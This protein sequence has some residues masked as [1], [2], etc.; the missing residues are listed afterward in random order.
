MKHF[1]I[2]TLFTLLLP[3]A[4]CTEKE[5]T[6]GETPTVPQT[7]FR[8]S[9]RLG[10]GA[11]TRAVGDAFAAQS[12]EKR[13]DRLAFFV[14][15]D[16]D[17]FQVYPPAPDDGTTTLADDPNHVH[18]TET[19]PAD[20]RQYTAEVI[21]TAGGGYMADIVAVAN[22]PE[23]YD[24]SQIITWQ[25]L[26]DSVLVWA[27]EMPSCTPGTGI[28]D[29]ARRA[30]VMYS[31][32]R[33][34][35]TK[36]ENN[37]FTL[38]MERLAAR[39]DIT[40]EAYVTG[41]TPADPKG[42]FLLSSVRLL[43]ARPASYITPQMDYTSPDVATVSNWEVTDIPYGKAATA[44]PSANP[45][46]E[47]DKVETADAETDATLQYLWRSLYT[48]ENSD[49]EHAPTALEIKGAFRGMEVTRRIDF[50]DKDK[51]PVPIVRNHRY[52]VRILP[53]P[54]LT[55]ITFDIKVSEWDAVDTVNVKPDQTEVPVISNMESNLT[56]YINSEGQKTY[57]LYYT[58]D[59]EMTFDATCSFAP[60]IRV[61]YYN[62]KTGTWTTDDNWITISKTAEEVIPVTRSANTY[63]CSY[64]V[65]FP[66][67]DTGLSRQA[68]LLVHN[69]GSEVECDTIRIKHT[70]TFPGTDLEPFALGTFNGKDIVWAPVNWG[71]TK[72]PTEAIEIPDNKLSKLTED[73][74]QKI[75]E[76]SGLYFQWGR[77]SGLNTF[78]TDNNLTMKPGPVSLEVSE[79]EEY[80]GFLIDGGFKTGNWLEPSNDQLWNKGTADAPVKGDNDP[81]PS[82]WRIS[83]KAELEVIAGMEWSHINSLH[84]IKGSKFV[85]YVPFIVFVVDFA[86]LQKNDAQSAYIFSSDA[87]VNDIQYKEAYI[88]NCGNSVIPYPRYYAAPIRCVQEQP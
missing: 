4:A 75:L 22:L 5:I 78:T 29:P 52:L 72:I 1:I 47:P 60:G 49:T 63:K 15:T 80:K 35:L 21:L 85:L 79:N 31:Y 82:G 20:S 14:H 54:G 33:H 67:F 68:M 59:G 23:D 71:A 53:A 34:E 58:Q 7:G 12:D 32:I 50:I 24:Y 11:A 51:Q 37:A 76:Q 39:I 45:T 9:A 42:G 10:Q 81:C 83:C 8:L 6:G 16:E 55:D 28:D 44:D 64:K 74:Y 40:N 2:S 17:G 86:S 61:K 30:F 18:L 38:A 73:D 77:K 13:I 26:Q 84:F 62:D 36:E 87:V 19:P 3:L 88:L 48:Y 70:V 25:G 27:T 41:M 56:E 66:K 57:D 65:T 43:H 69:G 46:G